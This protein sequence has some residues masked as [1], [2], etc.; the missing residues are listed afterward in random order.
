MALIVRELGPL[1]SERAFRAS[2][3]E[4]AEPRENSVCHLLQGVRDSGGYEGGSWS[5]LAVGAVKLMLAG[6]GEEDSDC[7]LLGWSVD[8]AVGMFGDPR[9]SRGCIIA[10][11][12]G[13]KSFVREERESHLDGW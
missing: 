6:V 12:N 11:Q 3:M 1:S 7:F 9:Y 4:F 8:I 5:L 10:V 2:S 13:L